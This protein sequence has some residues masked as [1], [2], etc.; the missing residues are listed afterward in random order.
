MSS[1]RWKTECFGEAHWPSLKAAKKFG[2][3]CIRK[4][5]PVV[6]YGPRGARIGVRPVL[7]KAKPV[8]RPRGSKRRKNKDVA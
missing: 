6:I 4:G 3:W 5:L 1:K 2:E 8:N 7:R